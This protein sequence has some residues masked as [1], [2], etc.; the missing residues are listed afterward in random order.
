MVAYKI[1]LS[2]WVI[3]HFDTWRAWNQITN[4]IYDLVSLLMSNKMPAFFKL[5][6]YIFHE[7]ISTGNHFV[8]GNTKP[9]SYLKHVLYTNFNLKT[10]FSPTRMDRPDLSKSLHLVT[11]HSS[12][13]L[14]KVSLVLDK[15]CREFYELLKKMWFMSEFQMAFDWLG[16]HH[17]SFLAY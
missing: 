5:R 10:N 14:K 4:T 1:L 9:N 3:P 7:S 6:S 15:W 11:L 12:H 2:R 13:L 16:F 17:I 8:L